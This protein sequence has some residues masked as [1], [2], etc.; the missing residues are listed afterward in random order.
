MFIY[1]KKLQYPVRVS[2]KD[3]RM[4]KAVLTQYGGPDGELSASMNYLTQRFSMPL[5]ELK[6]ILTDIGTEELVP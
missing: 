5:N 4:A 3:V 6:A 2:N 1:E